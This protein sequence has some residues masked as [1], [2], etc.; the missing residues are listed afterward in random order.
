M[1]PG[2]YGRELSISQAR[3]IALAAQGFADPAPA[4]RVDRRH[5]RRVMGR[6][7]LLQLDS[8]PVVIR[9]QYLPPFSRLGCYEPSLL[10][11]IA[12]RDDEWF[13]AWAH[14]ASLVPVDDEPL[15][16]WQKQRSEQGQTWKGLVE[17]ARCE[18]D[19]VADVLAQVAE[20]PLAAG[21][22]ADPRRRDGEW[23][24]SRSLGSMA[25]DWLFRIGA[26]GIRRRGNFVKEFDLLERIVPPD[27]LARPT[28]T[29][30]EAQR[31]LLARSGAA[32]GVGAAGDLVDYYRLPPR[33]GRV[34]LGELVE[35]GRLETVAVQGWAEAAYMH[36]AARLPRS[37]DSLTVLSPFDPIVW[38]RSRAA[39]LWDFDYR[40][41]IYVPASK[42]VYGYYVLPVL[43]GEQLAGRLDLKTDR[44]GGMLRVLGAFAEP[45]ADRP[46]LAERLRPHLR[47]LARF[48]GVETV[49]YGPR[50]DL[51]AALRPDG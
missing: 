6:V 43:A 22:L 21:E 47:D 29:A 7:K 33:E 20:R 49:S 9:T 23:W 13:E 1:S 48:V 2:R 39:R 31:E 50:G 10:D 35:A 40:I 24:G 12:Y 38:N 28:P 45:G 32:L 4:G 25:L 41:E 30:E 11:R 42:R 51:M 46:E 15:L 34:R 17:L 36:P 5:L 14:E 19:Y 18:S 8:V 3:R 16:R 26:V 44:A 27:V 37:A